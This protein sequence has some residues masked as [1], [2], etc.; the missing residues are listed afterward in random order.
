[1][2]KIIYSIIT[3][4]LI[5]Y[6][7]LL[8]AQSQKIEIQQPTKETSKDNPVF[9][10]ALEIIQKHP[11]RIEQN[12]AILESVYPSDSDNALL[13]LKLAAY[14]FQLNRTEK[15]VPLIQKASRL[16]DKVDADLPFYEAWCFQLDNNF[17]EAEKKYL[18][19]KNHINAGS[20][21]LRREIE[22][23][24]VE[25]HAGDSLLNHP[26][27]VSIVNLGNKINTV[28]AE[29]TPIVNADE[30]SLFFT[31]RK[32]NDGTQEHYEKIFS[33]NKVNGSWSNPVQIQF[34]DEMEVHEALSGL[35]PDGHEMLVYQGDVNKGDIFLS[36]YSNGKWSSMK[37]LGKNINTNWHE[38]SACLSPQANTLYFVSDRPGGLGGRDIYYSNYDREK[39]SWGTAINIGAPINTAFDEEGV[40]LHPG[41]RILYF[42]SKGHAGMGGYDIYYSELKDGKW[43]L[44]VNVGYPL[45]TSS[46]DVYAS[47]SAD[48]KH[49]Y[50]SS[51]R[52]EGIGEKDI[53]C[54]TFNDKPGALSNMILITGF[55]KD[56]NDSA[57]S[58]NID[59][60]DLQKDIKLGSYKTDALTGKY[61][62]P[63]PTGKKYGLVVY[64]EGY[65]FESENIDVN[66]TSAYRHYT[67]QKKLKKM[68]P[69]KSTLLNN[70]FFGKGK[71]EPLGE[72]INE[73]NRVY[74]LL[75]RYPKL[76]VEI[77]GYTDNVGSDEFNNKLSTQ[78]AKSVY[79]YLVTKGINKSRLSFAGYGKANPIA[80][81]DTEEG[82]KINRRIEFRIVEI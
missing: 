36:S 28:F 5:T 17:E 19:F 57:L 29:M 4:F 77:S 60:F 52:K 23:R 38:S 8:H 80:G 49:I 71:S 37:D 62:V 66:D 82:R 55:V 21:E 3:C 51:Q 63:L 75:K 78:R 14:Y 7:D 41:G 12:L 25:C 32:F 6:C 73:L 65:L 22:Q 46:D 58:A 1:M 34:S 69:G 68:Q 81:N 79:D 18:E 53:Y 44:P 26:V 54:A 33:S 43:Q 74:D 70:L 35:F 67:Y 48:G 10:R 45:N 50:F 27:N 16:N 61:T 42:A 76:K 64:S 72:S 56:E 11:E 47:L 39:G 20:L 2:V 15:A 9:K 59:L 31:A 13:N 40:F 24:L 30:S